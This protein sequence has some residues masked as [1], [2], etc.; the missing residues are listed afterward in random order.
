MDQ[1]EAPQSNS[2]APQKHRARRGEGWLLR[3]EILRVGE[4]LLMERQNAAQVSI[5]EIAQEARCTPPA[6]YRHFPDKQA[7]IMEI[8]RRFL[9]RF[10]TEVSRSRD[11]LVSDP[12]EQLILGAHAYVEFGLRYPEPYRILFMS[13]PANGVVEDLHGPALQTGALDPTKRA[14][15]R[16]L[17]AGVELPGDAFTI[18][19]TVWANAHGVVSLLIS[20]PDFPWP[21]LDEFLKSSL[22]VYE[23]KRAHTAKLRLT[24]E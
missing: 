22:L 9:E 14:A 6:I 4:R 16:C 19:C 15:Q 13:H 1:D 18:A 11:L 23:W 5:A 3:E 12:L 21:P 7:L 24:H 17:D 2:G 10:R 20:R 8:S